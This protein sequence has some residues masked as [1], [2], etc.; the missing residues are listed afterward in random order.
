MATQWIAASTVTYRSQHYTVKYNKN[1][2][3]ILHT[4][5]GVHAQR[6]GLMS[7]REVPQRAGVRHSAEQTKRRVERRTNVARLHQLLPDPRLADSLLHA[8]WV[9]ALSTATQ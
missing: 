6:P 1:L 5:G 8:R 7:L 9:H 3:R 4:S 2:P